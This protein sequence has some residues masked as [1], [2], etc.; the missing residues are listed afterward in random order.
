MTVYPMSVSS[1]EH[2]PAFSPGPEASQPWFRERELWV[3]LVLTLAIFLPRLTLLTIRGEESRRAVIAREMMDT[4]DWIVPRTQGVVRLSRPPLQNWMIAGSAYLTGGMSA[5]AVRLPGLFGTLMTVAVIY[6]YARSRLDV[7]AALISGL[8]YASMLQVLEQGRTGE[9]EPV[10]TAMITAALLLWHGGLL[11]HWRPEFFWTVGAAFG[12]L[13]MLTK[14]LQAPIYF[15]GPTWAYFVLTGQWR[16]L[17][18]R[19]HLLGVLTFGGIVAAWQIPFMMTMGLQNGWEIYFWNVKLRFHD[20][21]TIT[22]IKHFLTYP[23]SVLCGCLAPWSLF[24]LAYGQKSIREHMQS[25]KEMVWFLAIAIAVCFP[26]VWIPPEARPRYF[27][28]LFPCF[29]VLIGVAI[30]LISEARLPATDRLWAVFVRAGRLVMFAAAIGIA[31]WGI[32]GIGACPPMLEA[33]GY[34]ILA[35]ILAVAMRRV[36]LEPTMATVRRGSVLMTM[37]LGL[38]YVLPILSN[39]AKR[40]ENLPAAMA[41]AQTKLPEDA[42]LVSF[43]HVHHLF[44]H[45]L[46]EPVKLIDVPEVSLSD[47]QGVDYFCIESLHGEPPR[48]P[49]AWTEIAALPMDRNK[50]EVP[51]V[52]VIIGRVQHPLTAI[53]IDDS[54]DRR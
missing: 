12:A 11:R 52:Q 28:P 38:T 16:Q 46:G 17:L 43:G 6:W 35:A 37:F 1:A 42:E 47:A 53:A 40:S 48:L 2:T 8:A 36:S 10:F 5:W 19:G 22:Y 32:I 50:H 4:G 31:A 34:G 51:E 54:S 39:Q 44:L 18:T 23:P 45:Y 29:A 33:V 7:N 41:D 30:T 3:L 49:F 9:T 14:G 24:L 26:S 25:R 21:R 13:A 27:M 20:N 15:F